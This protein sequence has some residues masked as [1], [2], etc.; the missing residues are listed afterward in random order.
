MTLR[1]EFLLQSVGGLASVRLL[2]S[3]TVGV[4]ALAGDERWLEALSTKKHRTF[5]DVMHFSPDG[6]PFRR[7]ATLVRVMNDHYGVR[8][9]DIGIA[10]GMHSAGLA[11]VVTRET[12]NELALTGWLASQLSGA[13][14][15]A[16]TANSTS[17][18]D[19]NG[20]SIHEMRSQGIRIL[21]CRETIGRW[22]RRVAVE[23]GR[24]V[25]EI[26]KLITEGLHDGV[27]PVP[28]MVAATLLAQEHGANYIASA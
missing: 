5:F 9:T 22:A 7:A 13:E 16:L 21:A 8:L 6:T 27:E 14:S 11:H 3:T 26:A 17:I 24:P 23:R 12:W 28:A 1:R 20:R 15:A 2:S 19:A 10:L 25:E 18:A 4:S